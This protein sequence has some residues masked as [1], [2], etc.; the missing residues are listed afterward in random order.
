MLALFKNKNVLLLRADWTRPDAAIATELS[1]LGRSGLPVYA[2]YLPGNQ[3]PLLLPELL[4]TSEL[5]AALS[6]L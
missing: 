3:P 2:L 1:N 5:Q 4:T 6:V